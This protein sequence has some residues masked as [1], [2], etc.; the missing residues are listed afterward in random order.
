MIV[1]CLGIGRADFENIT[2]LSRRQPDVPAR[3]RRRTS[4]QLAVDEAESP[5]TLA[6]APNCGEQF[7][8]DHVSVR[9]Q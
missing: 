8:T 7:E 3:L 6:C 1:G 9:Q 2:E 5:D 4:A